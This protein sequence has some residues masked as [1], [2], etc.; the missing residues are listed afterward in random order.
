MP[1]N[2]RKLAALDM[3]FL[4]SGVILSEFALG[5]LGPIAVGIFTVERGRSQWQSTVGVYLILLGFNYIPLLVYAIAIYRKGSAHDEIADDL[6]EKTE[7]AKR[8]FPQ[9]LLLLIPLV[10]P[11]L[12]L[13]QERRRRK[14]AVV[15]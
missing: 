5:V 11:I 2:I 4:G 13:F 3:A 7:I 1:I 8:Y 12:A 6:A 10:M 9:T 14:T 15:G